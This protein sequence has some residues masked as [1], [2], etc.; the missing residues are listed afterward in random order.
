MLQKPDVTKPGIAMFPNNVRAIEADKCPTCGKVIK[1]S[2]F[3][4]GLSKTE[5][6]I[7]GMCQE[8][9]DKVFGGA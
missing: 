4:H 7:S 5:Y 8:C 9:Q 1:E 2:D 3:R 6:S